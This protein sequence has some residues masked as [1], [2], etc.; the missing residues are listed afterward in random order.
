[1]DRRHF[2]ALALAASMPPR[3][4]AAA[5]PWRIGFLS[6]AA[7]NYLVEQGHY[8]AFLEGMNAAGYVEGR[9]FVIDWRDADG[10]YERLPALAAELVRIPVDIIVAVPSPAI[11]AAQKATSSIPIVFP[12]TGDPVGSGFAATLARPGGNLTGI[13]NG[14]LDVSAKTLQMLAAVVPRLTRIALLVN[15]GS[16]TA[17]NIVRSVQSLAG[18][19]GVQVAVVEMS[20]SIP[21]ED[22][23]AAMKRARIDAFLIASESFLNTQGREI[24]RWA[25]RERLPSMSQGRLYAVAGGLMAYGTDV[26]EGYRRAAVY[27]DKI[28]KGAR[29]GDLPIEQ[30]TQLSLTINMRTAKELAITFPQAL[31]V[32]ASE[33]IQ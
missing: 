29:P 3:L 25:V 23:F 24:A 11:R 30:P 16:L 14:D 7:R 5:K 32:Q 10:H 15:P 20:A 1:M 31:L 4:A 2:L 21:M 6:T 9:D 18:A 33:L 22:A 19:M 28:L 8:P 17:P 26:R 13:S 27:V 12:T